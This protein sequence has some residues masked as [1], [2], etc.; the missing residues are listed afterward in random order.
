MAL[1]SRRASPEPL[2]PPI[3]P[4]ESVDEHPFRGWTE[5]LAI[6]GLV[7]SEHRLSDVLNRRE[8]FRV[9]G[10]GVIEI[11]AAAGNRFNQPEMSVDPFDFE[12]VLGLRH[13]HGQADGRSPRRIH[14]VRYQVEIRAGAFVICGNLHVF[15]GNSPESAAHYS[16]TLFLPITEPTVRRA[17]R[18]ISD[19][20]VV[21]AFVNRHSIQ[22][23]NQLDLRH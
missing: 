9:D 11:G 8:V 4:V 2:P 13:R 23:I 12:V 15:P 16:G 3:I 18:L 5:S 21:V 22:T 1:W 7:R 20:T 14:K 19:P 17:G 10:P 6:S